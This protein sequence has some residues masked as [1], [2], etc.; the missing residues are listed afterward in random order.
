M[1]SPQPLLYLNEALEQGEK[2]LQQRNGKAA[3]RQ[4]PVTPKDKTSL[5]KT[6]NCGKQPNNQ[7]HLYHSLTGI[8]RH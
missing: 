8:T 1:S 4:A 6:G 5:N 7:R 2:D 3:P